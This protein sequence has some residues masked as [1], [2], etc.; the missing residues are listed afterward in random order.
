MT[1]AARSAAGGRGKWAALRVEL[2]T[3]VVECS[4]RSATLAKKSRGALSKSP[5]PKHGAFVKKLFYP[6]S[7]EARAEPANIRAHNVGQR[8]VV[9]HEKQVSQAEQNVNRV[10]AEFAELRK[11]IRHTQ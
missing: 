4:C 5:V 6:F 7:Q 2:R 11:H 1:R 3:E 9:H 10:F 8:D